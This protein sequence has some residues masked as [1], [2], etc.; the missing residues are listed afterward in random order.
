MKSFVYENEDKLQKY[1]T[2]SAYAVAISR[3][4]RNN[5]FISIF[6]K[7]AFEKT[8]EEYDNGKEAYDFRCEM[9]RNKV[10]SDAFNYLYSPFTKNGSRDNN[11]GLGAKWEEYNQMSIPE[12]ENFIRSD[13]QERFDKIVEK[14]KTEQMTWGYLL[15]IIII[16]SC[17]CISVITI[18]K[19][20]ERNHMARKIALYWIICLLISIILLSIGAMTKAGDD[21]DTLLAWLIALII[22]SII[23]SS[24][25]IS[26]LTKKSTQDYCATFLIPD[27]LLNL[28]HISNEFRKRLL[29]LFL[30][31]PFFFIVPIPIAGLFVFI[32]YIIPVIVILGIIRLVLWIKEGKRIDTKLQIQNDR[33]RLYCRHCGKLIDAD[34]D[35]CRYCG[36]KL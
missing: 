31:Y 19:I 1:R 8:I 14:E 18:N 28:L 24:L 5:Q 10:V 29:M 17:L 30:I 3:L 23:L 33:A 26:F 15:F 7:E 12:K 32:C 4:Y 11:K 35:F 27:R 25:V 20:G 36:K 6:G 21:T 2:P 34:S 9:L 22:P 13:F 16:I